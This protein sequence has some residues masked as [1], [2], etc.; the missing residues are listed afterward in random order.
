MNEHAKPLDAD[1]IGLPW[2]DQGTTR[3]GLDCR[4]LVALWLREQMGFE[5]TYPK[6]HA[7]GDEVAEQAVCGALATGQQKPMQ[8]GDVVFF[9]DRRSGKVRH[10]AV[11]LGE[12]GY[13]HIMS[14]G[15]ARIDRSMTLLSRVGLDYCGHLGVHQTAALAAAL[16]D[17][18]LGGIDPFTWAL[19]FVSIALSAASAFLMPKPKLGQ[20]RPESGRYGFDN[21]ITQTNPQL[22]LPDIMGAVSVAGNSPYQSRV[23]KSQ[24]ATDA[25]QQGVNKVVIVGSGPFTAWEYN[26]AVIKIDGRDY[27]D[28]FWHPSGIALDPAQDKDSA[29][30]GTISGE[31]GH[32]S[33]STYLGSHAISV[34]VDVRAQY[35]RNFPLYGFNGCAYL[36][37]R[38]IDSSKFQSFNLTVTPKGRALRTFNS[39][40]FITATATTEAV[41]TGDGSTVRFKLAF[42][43]VS[44]VSSVTVGG[45][46]YAAA[47]ATQPDG[48]VYALNATKGYIEFPTAP[49][50]AAA[51]VATYT[52]YVRA[53]TQNP[54]VQ[55]VAMLTE[56]DRGKGFPEAKVDFAAADT[57]Q[58]HNDVQLLWQGAHAQAVEVRHTSNYAVDYRKPAQDHVRAILDAAYSYLFLSNGKF[59]IKPRGTGSSVFSFTT[60]SMLKDTFS[61]EQLDRS[62]LANR[63]KVNFR[64]LETYNAEAG[65][66]RED[67]DDQRARAGYGTSEG[68]VEETL[69]MVAVDRE[70]H[71]ERLAETVLRENVRTGWVVEFKTTVKGLALEPGDIIDVTHP[72]KPSWAAKLF[73]IEDLEL[74]EQDRLKLKCSEYLASCYT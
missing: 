2:K 58:Q 68:V 48:A 25:T 46:T 36:V 69:Q 41:G 28:T 12:P 60:A 64:P 70:T 71:A 40:G 24:A 51:I 38:L 16:S 65:V 22:P 32:P 11:Y 67:E 8:R 61:A 74:D 13:L 15:A 62:G 17:R 3:A 4:G 26:S 37:F 35:D 20:F 72:A 63:V 34:P 19:I 21:L 42:A 57:A 54:A 7:E 10:V 33:I 47:S 73:R 59:V 50:A 56:A 55:A 52:Y 29:V 53:W 45:T 9:R 31:G 39:S 66:T 1:Y 30:E 6:A 18:K 5:A 49:A 43:D 23:D 27:R 44:A 14:A